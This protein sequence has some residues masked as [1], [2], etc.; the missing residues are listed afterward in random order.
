MIN[1]YKTFVTT[2]I[3]IGSNLEATQT[4]IEK[5][6]QQLAKLPSTIL[7][8]KSSLYRTAPIEAYGNHYINAVIQLLTTLA[9]LDL[10]K[11][12]Q[13]IE[14]QYGRKRPYPNAPRTLDLDI[15]LY[16]DQIIINNQLTIPH[17]RMLKRAFVLIPMLEINPM[18][19]VPGFGKITNLDSNILNQIIEPLF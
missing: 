17:P 13:L 6:I 16:G 7:N 11:T 8:A 14:F 1:L 4:K 15:L 18:I 5:V 12:L 3:S 9:P 19:I 10:L 2:Y